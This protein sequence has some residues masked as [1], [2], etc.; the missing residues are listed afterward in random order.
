MAADDRYCANCRAPLPPRATSCGNCGVYTG[1]VFDGRLPRT[2]RRSAWPAVLIVLLL[3]C[4]IAAWLLWPRRPP[5]PLD[6]GPA[7]VLRGVP[8]ASQRPAGAKLNQAEAMRALRRFLVSPGQPNPVKSECLAVISR[9]YRDG[10]YRFNAV[11]SCN[12]TRLGIWEVNANS[13]KVS[14]G[15]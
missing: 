15:Q 4:G 1:D 2:R 14:R 8:G 11:N 7:R 3:A 13:E 9:G 10:I 6:T 5:L 12:G